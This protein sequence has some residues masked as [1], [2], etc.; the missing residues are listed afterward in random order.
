[1]LEH[2]LTRDKDKK[3]IFEKMINDYKTDYFKTLT[4]IHHEFLYSSIHPSDEDLALC[5]EK[6][7]YP[8]TLSMYNLLEMQKD[9]EGNEIPV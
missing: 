5:L 4:T 3:V 6:N 2:K 1:M 7:I 8:S 9:S